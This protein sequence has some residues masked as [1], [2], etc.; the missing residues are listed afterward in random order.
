M[1]RTVRQALGA[2][3]DFFVNRFEC[4]HTIFASVRQIHHNQ[5]YQD[6]SE[7]IRA[8]MSGQKSFLLDPICLICSNFVRFKTNE[9]TKL[10]DATVSLDSNE[11]TKNTITVN[12]SIDRVSHQ[13]RTKA[14]TQAIIWPRYERFL[15]ILEEME[16]S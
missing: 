11:S 16:D 4:N 10:R 14:K 7:D 15:E 1:K 9:V 2:E 13:V 8:I 6:I 3:Y 5:I 12:V